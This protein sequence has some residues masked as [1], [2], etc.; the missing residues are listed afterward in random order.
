MAN[1]AIYNLPGQQTLNSSDIIIIDDGTTTNRTEI[2][3]LTSYLQDNLTIASTI[4]DIGGLQ[5]A[6]D[7]KANTNHT[8]IIGDIDGLQSDLDTRL[9]TSQAFIS[10]QTI[11]I[12]GVSLVVPTAVSGGSDARIPDSTTANTY[13][14]FSGTDGSL[15]P[16]TTSQVRSDLSLTDTAITAQAD[17]AIST[18]TQTAIDTK[19][20]TLEAL[21]VSGAYQVRLKAGETNLSVAAIPAVT[22]EVDGIMQAGDKSKLDGIEPLADVTD[23]ENVWASVGISLEGR[24]SWVLSERGV[25]VP[26][27]DSTGNI[28]Q[29]VSS[30]TTLQT[31]VSSGGGVAQFTITGVASTIVNVSIVNSNPANWIVANSL[32]AQQITLGEDGTATVNVTIPSFSDLTGTRTFQVEAQAD[33]DFQPAVTSEVVTQYTASQ[34]LTGIMLANLSFG[35]TMEVETITVTGIAGEGYSLELFDVTPAG[36]ITSGA[37]S[38]TT[39]VIGADGTDGSHTITLPVDDDDT[40]TRSFRLRARAADDASVFVESSLIVQSHT[41]TQESGNLSVNTNLVFASGGIDISVTAL[42]GDAPFTATLLRDSALTVPNTIEVLEFSDLNT[43]Q[44]FATLQASDYSAEEHTF[45]VHVRDTDSDTIIAM[46]VVDLSASMNTPPSG[47]VSQT[48]GTTAPAIGDT[49]EFTAAYND[50]DG[51][52]LTYQWQFSD[53]LG[54]ITNLDQAAA[55]LPV[56]DNGNSVRISWNQTTGTTSAQW[57]R[58]DGATDRAGLQLAVY[59]DGVDHATTPPVFIYEANSSTVSFTTAFT[60][61]DGTLLAST[62][63]TTDLDLS[64]I[65]DPST[66]GAHLSSDRYEAFS[67]PNIIERDFTNYTNLQAPSPDWT[68]GVAKDDYVAIDS[69]IATS[70]ASPPAAADGSALTVNYFAAFGSTFGGVRV[71][72]NYG[73]DPVVIAIWNVNEDHSTTQPHYVAVLSNHND[74]EIGYPDGYLGNNDADNAQG[75]IAIASGT[76]MTTGGGADQDWGWFSDDRIEIFAVDSVADIPT[77]L[78]NA[79]GVTLSIDAFEGNDLT[80]A[81]T[82]SP[83]LGV[84]DA[85]NSGQTGSDWPNDVLDGFPAFVRFTNSQAI[86]RWSS[87]VDDSYT[88]NTDSVIGVWEIGANHVMDAPL[89]VGS[90]TSNNTTPGGFVSADGDVFNY[91]W[92]G[93]VG[94][95]RRAELTAIIS[96][97]GTIS[98][99]RNID[100]GSLPSTGHHWG[101]AADRI[102]IIMGTTSIPTARMFTAGGAGSFRVQVSDGTDTVTS[103]EITIT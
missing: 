29:L 8:H 103:N 22:T 102:E 43:P 68:S 95:A 44:Q 57:I 79:N 58:P 80:G 41:Q 42:T 38:A 92:G 1:I 63:V 99:D 75:L 18:A 91:R 45:Y 32:S 69:S 85:A 101:L 88:T 98:T 77:T 86:T 39:G 53:E 67:V 60:N 62:Q 11:N 4:G 33:G 23:T 19:G 36:W 7:G 87:D 97:D 64:S 21:N 72:D 83:S 13:P 46:E 28:E 56:D 70:E 55:S 54:P 2:A 73:N 81:I 84:L 89:W 49:V 40:Y 24:T 27:P 14:R 94:S 6:L 65:V 47:S 35:N 17:L 74:T 3:N 100:G 93:S 26:L 15:E 71:N 16:R 90:D 51:D 30:V 48:T 52:D 50:P 34:L 82:N 5:A 37:L 9:S 10:G 66:F 76:G 59:E 78:T 12:S 96:A 31:T 20:D 25:M 61:P